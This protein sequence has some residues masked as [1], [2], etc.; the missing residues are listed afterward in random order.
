MDRDLSECGYI[1]KKSKYPKVYEL[2]KVITHNKDSIVA[3]ELSKFIETIE[4]YRFNELELELAGYKFTTLLSKGLF[5]YRDF[6]YYVLNFKDFSALGIDTS[7]IKSSMEYMIRFLGVGDGIDDKN[8][9]LGIKGD[10]FN[11]AMCEVV[12]PVYLDNE[13]IINPISNNKD[14]LYA[15]LTRGREE[16]TYFLGHMSNK[17]S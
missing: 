17:L 15:R 4:L 7:K 6:K 5:W 11:I 8:F 9:I 16:G 13:L 14:C 3:F 2:E 1:V 10:E 12:L